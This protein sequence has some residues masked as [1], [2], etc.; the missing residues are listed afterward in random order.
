MMTIILENSCHF[1]WL[2]N[3]HTHICRIRSYEISQSKSFVYIFYSKSFILRKGNCLKAIQVV[4]DKITSIVN[5]YMSVWCFC[6]CKYNA[7]TH[8][9]IH[10][11]NESFLYIHKQNKKKSEYYFLFFKHYFKSN[12]SSLIHISIKSFNNT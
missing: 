11:T 5:E 9:N 8:R 10:Y 2:W 4:C 1:I 7:P 6:V 3:P 12:I